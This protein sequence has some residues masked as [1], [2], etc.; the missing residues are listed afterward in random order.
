MVIL[1]GLQTIMPISTDLYLPALPTIA[2]DLNVSAGAAQFTLAVF[3]IGVATGQIAYGPITDTYGRKRPLLIGLAV[4]IL[5]ATICALAPTIS[6]LIGGRFLQAIGAAAGAVIA[7][8]IARDLWSGKLL[9][10]RL[11]LLF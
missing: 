7:I 6:M 9:A 2:R 1:G 3:M 4:Y 10:D 8:A 5:G 11:S